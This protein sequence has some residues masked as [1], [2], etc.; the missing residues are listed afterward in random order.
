MRDDGFRIVPPGET[1]GA[2][3]LLHWLKTHVRMNK[4]SNRIEIYYSQTDQWTEVT[5]ENFD[6][7]CPIDFFLDLSEYYVWDEIQR[8]ARRQVFSGQAS[9]G[10]SGML[11]TPPVSAERSVQTEF[12]PHGSTTQ[13]TVNSGV[14]ETEKVNSIEEISSLLLDRLY[15]MKKEGIP[16]SQIAFDTLMQSQ[17]LGASEQ[18]KL[19]QRLQLLGWE[20][21]RTSS[22]R[23]WIKKHVGPAAK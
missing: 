4:V 14:S 9:V 7:Y 23:L 2:G 10:L 17:P 8:A 15:S 20:A 18:K 19:A 5:S 6:A 13:E 21:K 22:S 16:L 1:A 12:R 3:N 11:C